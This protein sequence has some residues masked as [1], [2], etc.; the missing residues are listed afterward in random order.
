VPNKGFIPKTNSS[1]RI[2]E[3]TASTKIKCEA[4]NFVVG[5]K[6][7]TEKE[8]SLQVTNIPVGMSKFIYIY[9]YIYH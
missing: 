8:F 1:L 4:S 9:L 7:V 2:N 6:V 5:E 3:A